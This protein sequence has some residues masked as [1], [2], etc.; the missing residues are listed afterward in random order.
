ML[1]I[2]L[3]TVF[4]FLTIQTKQTS[5]LVDVSSSIVVCVWDIWAHIFYYSS[6]QFPALE[7]SAPPDTADKAKWDLHTR[8]Q[9]TVNGCRSEA[10]SL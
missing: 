5:V 3:S 7:V 1:L 4:T 10:F 8:K 6:G 9:I 2:V